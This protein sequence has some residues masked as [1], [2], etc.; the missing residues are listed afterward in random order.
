MRQILAFVITALLIGVATMAPIDLPTEPETPVVREYPGMAT[1]VGFCPSWTVEGGVTSALVI[2]MLE[3]SEVVA[4]WHPDSGSVRL[5]A[6]RA[7]AGTVVVDPGLAQGNVP[8]LVERVSGGPIAA[9]VVTEGEAM[10]AAAGCARWS[11]TRWV[12]GIGGTLERESTVLFLHN[13]SAQSAIVSVET[14]S[15]QGY[16]VAP[17]L[18]AV[19]V[20]PA[21]QVEIDISATLRLR[22]Q[23]VFIVDDPLGAVV[24]ALEHR[25]SGPD[26]GITTGA[27]ESPAWY[28]P[29]RFAGTSELVIVNPASFEVAVEIDLYGPDGAEVSAEVELLASRSTWHLDVAEGTAVHVRADNPIGAAMRTET[30]DGLA[31]SL[32]AHAEADAWMLPGAGLPGAETTVHLL[33][34]ATEPVTA[35]YRV[36][37]PGGAT[38][39]RTITIPALS[40][41]ERTLEVANAAAIFVEAEAPV[42][43][44]WVARTESG[45]IAVDVGVPMGAAAD[46]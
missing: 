38:E 12:V 13:P 4:A 5:R 7:D 34:T 41:F 21:S 24:P 36:L 19:T 37:G 18:A 45:A 33:N 40:V 39:P 11:A 43:A 28:F 17:G 16:E 23:I 14:Y 42:T 20:P 10:R 2:A 32:G 8:A 1:G 15:E 26:R 22:D 31:L 9:G 35:T 25:G 3:P 29:Q 44:A 30:A 46:D 6:E 27:P